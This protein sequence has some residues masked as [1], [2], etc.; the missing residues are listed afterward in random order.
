MVSTSCGSAVG[1]GRL[2]GLNHNPAGWLGLKVAAVGESRRFR[3][4]RRLWLWSLIA[5]VAMAA[6]VVLWVAMFFINADH[7]RE[8]ALANGRD[9]QITY[10]GVTILTGF[11]GFAA[12]G[13]QLS[14]AQNPEARGRNGVGDALRT[15][16]VLLVLA[17]TVRG[18]YVTVTTSC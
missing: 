15:L 11:F 4:R 14:I 7:C 1:S 5:S 3:V 8:M 13:I 10:I 12:L 17:V 6:D 16:F 2:T 18:L 9:G